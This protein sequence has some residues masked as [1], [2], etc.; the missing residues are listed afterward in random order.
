MPR[1]GS[2]GACRKYPENA[3][4]DIERLREFMQRPENQHKEIRLAAFSPGTARSPMMTLLTL[5]DRVDHISQLLAVRG[6]PIGTSRGFIH[7]ALLAPSDRSDS[8]VRNERVEVWLAEPAAN[9][10]GDG[11]M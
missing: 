6:V 11:P 1:S 5:N 3:L 2:P 9:Y 4:R 10:S 7:G 8:R